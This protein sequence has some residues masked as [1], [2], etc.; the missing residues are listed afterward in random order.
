MGDLNSNLMALSSYALDSTKKEDLL[1]QYL[2]E[3]LSQMMDE[4]HK[5]QTP[6]D[7]DFRKLIHWLRAGDQLTHQ[8]HP[9]P[10]K[11][12]PHIAYFF[13]KAHKN[14]T[15]K[16]VLDP[17]CGSGT[18]ALEASIHG[19]LPLVADANPLALLLTKVKTT[20]Y[21]IEKLIRIKEKIS[22]KYIRYKVAPTIDIVNPDL[23]YLPE[24][25][26]RLEILLRTI[27]EVVDQEEKA[28]FKICFSSLTKKVSFADPAISVPVRLKTKEKFSPT[29][30]ARINKRLDWIKSANIIQEFNIIV[31]ANIERVIETNNKYPNRFTAK[32][33]GIDARSLFTNP[34]GSIPMPD[35]SVP[36]VITSPPYGSAQKYVRASSLSL[37]WLELAS[38]KE[39]RSLEE[40]SI[41]REHLK[42]TPLCL[43][44]SNLPQ[45]YVQLLKK[46]AL[47][48]E[49][50]A[51][52]TQKY[53][54]EMSQV[55]D[56]ISR[57]T[58]P[59]GRVIFVLGNNQVCGETLRNDRFIIE[60]F[61]KHHLKL[62]LILIDD[63]K[64]R[65]LMTKRNRTASVISRE[66]VLVFEK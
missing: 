15:Q 1:D 58:A 14:L 48:N 63:I 35:N 46:I 44:E 52:I 47:K 32:Q 8:I 59:N 13:L 25:K 20:P 38:P 61:Q 19:F 62:K 66:T 9:Y 64:S 41:G 11:L 39:L 3:T 55:V 16:L 43:E 7:I 5:N 18:V 51:Q 42:K 50:R 21:C 10:A 49:V 57:V 29:I 45:D 17:F 53:L 36:L 37:N 24:H 6:I 34:N 33:V 31:D 30:N 2:Q 23:W 65:G 26:K 56:E 22:Y 12:L 4:Y 28:F 54:I 27:E 60:C 40:K